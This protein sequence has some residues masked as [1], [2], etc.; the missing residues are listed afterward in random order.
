M[1]NL[2][3]ELL[4]SRQTGHKKENMDTEYRDYLKYSDYD[5]L[6]AILKSSG[7]FFPEEI[8]IALELIEENLT[9]GIESGYYFILSLTDGRVSGYSCYG[10]I[11]CTFNRWDIYWLAVDNSF[12][13]KG[14]GAGLLER[15]EEHIR[16][17]GGKRSYIETSSRDLY[18]PTR[19][20]HEKMGY[21]LETVQKDYYDDG[22]DKCLYVKI[23]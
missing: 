19:H 1:L 8:S 12:R 7:Y 17:L 23:L 13:N 2:S 14:I 21:V 11:P 22:D 16:K 10:P 6:N 18:L 9:R 3:A 15:S 20:F 4:L 5:D